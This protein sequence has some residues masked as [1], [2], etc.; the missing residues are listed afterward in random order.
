MIQPY[1]ERMQDDILFDLTNLTWE[2]IEDEDEF[3]AVL[4][5]LIEEETKAEMNDNQKDGQNLV[6]E[7]EV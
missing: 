1:V 5:V 3:S 6:P 7:E 2:L 4:Q